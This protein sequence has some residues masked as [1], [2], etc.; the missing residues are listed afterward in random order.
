M[1]Y[2]STEADTEFGVKADDSSSSSS[3]RQYILRLLECDGQR[4]AFS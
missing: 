2:I 1:D 3:I 4:S